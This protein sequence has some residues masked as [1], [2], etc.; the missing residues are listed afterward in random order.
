MGRIKRLAKQ[1]HA[2]L[3]ERFPIAF[4]KDY[5]AISPLKLGI[6]DD[7]CNALGEGIDKAVV[8]KVIENQTGRDGYL[9]ALIRQDQRID[10]QGQ[11]AGVISAEAK[12]MA[13]KRI[14]ASQRRQQAKSEKRKA[15]KG[16]LRRLRE[17][18]AQRRREYE[19]RKADKQRRREEHARRVAVAAERKKQREQRSP[20][21]PSKPT[22]V[23]KKRRR[24]IPR[25]PD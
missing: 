3:T 22:I 1:L 21:T 16:E 5:K 18:K 9:L 6:Y 2:E 12:A 24:R 17:A 10:L 15:L 13:Q 25:R 11:L 23:I 19:A 14:E 20:T 8:K 4:P 7:L